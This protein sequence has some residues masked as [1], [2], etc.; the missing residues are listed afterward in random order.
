M[1]AGMAWHWSGEGG[2]ST[3]VCDVGTFFALHTEALKG[4]VT[5]WKMMRHV[6]FI[7]VANLSRIGIVETVLK[8]PKNEPPFCTKHIRGKQT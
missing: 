8:W 2:S 6:N 4:L 3:R 1:C 5:L 7:T